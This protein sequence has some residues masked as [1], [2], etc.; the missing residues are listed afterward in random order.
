MKL[1]PAAKK[2][3]NTMQGQIPGRVCLF[4]TCFFKVKAFLLTLFKR[5][6]FLCVLILLLRICFSEFITVPDRKQKAA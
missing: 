3:R 5:K 2:Y 6:T 1:R 4:L